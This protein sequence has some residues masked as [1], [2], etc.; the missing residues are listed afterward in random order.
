MLLHFPWQVKG[1]QKSSNMLLLDAYYHISLQHTFLLILSIALRITIGKCALCLH[2]PVSFPKIRAPT[3]A[4]VYPVPPKWPT[5]S[6]FLSMKK[7][8]PSLGAPKTIG[9]IFHALREASL[10]PQFRGLASPHLFTIPIYHT[11]TEKNEKPICSKIYYAAF[12][13]Y[14]RYCSFPLHLPLAAKSCG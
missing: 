6:Y 4:P 12:L 5:L 8:R 14:P 9:A 2:P 11:S 10:F 3:P 7:E 13:N 1:Y